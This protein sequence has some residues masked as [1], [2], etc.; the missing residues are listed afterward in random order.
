MSIPESHTF[1]S[2]TAFWLAAPRD[3]PLIILRDA[4]DTNPRLFQG[5]V[6]SHQD[7]LAIYF[8]QH[9]RGT[10]VI[11]GLPYAMARGDIYLMGFGAVH[12][13]VDCHNLE[14]DALYFPLAFFDEATLAILGRQPTLRPFLTEDGG[15]GRWKHLSPV[16]FDAM[17]AELGELKQAWASVTEVGGL[18]THALFLRLLIHLAQWT[19]AF[20]RQTVMEAPTAP[21]SVEEAVARAVHLLETGF[22]EPLHIDDVAR[23]VCMSPDWLTKTFDRVTGRTPRD[24]LRALRLDRAKALLMTT[25]A[26]M[27]EIALASGFGDS[28]YFARVFREETGITPSHFR[29]QHRLP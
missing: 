2:V 18:L 9:G 22:T 8:V 21:L 12:Q 28:A 29:T 7:F 16:S 4:L 26:S 20:D 11:N 23:A 17:N 15:G 27:T 5:Q 24:Y 13:Y 19:D 25:S 1:A 10:H 6:N 3:P 14:V